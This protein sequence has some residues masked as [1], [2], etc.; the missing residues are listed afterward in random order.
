MNDDGKPTSFL[1]SMKHFFGYKDGQTLSEFSA[2]MKALTPA[3]RDYF[4][5]GLRQNGYQI[6]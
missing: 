4:T 3:D 6:P 1:A 2:E 5:I